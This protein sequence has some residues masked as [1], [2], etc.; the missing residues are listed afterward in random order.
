MTN[1][2]Q[3]MH[4]P[5]TSCPAYFDCKVSCTR[6]PQY[7]RYPADLFDAPLLFPMMLYQ[8][9]PPAFGTCHYNQLGHGRLSHIQTGCPCT[10]MWTMQ[11]NQSGCRQLA[12][13]LPKRLLG[14]LP[15]CFGDTGSPKLGSLVE[16]GLPNGGLEPVPQLAVCGERMGGGMWV[17]GRCRDLTLHVEQQ[18]AEACQADVGQRQ[19][20]I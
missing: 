20:R 16:A 5:F 13:P 15:D 3:D 18:T 9:L 2:S 19:A 11:R 8:L 6:G 12:H 1:C 7:Q 14:R 17:R 4:C 10:S